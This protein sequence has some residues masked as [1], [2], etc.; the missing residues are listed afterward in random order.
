MPVSSS[1]R[2]LVLRE[3]RHTLGGVNAA[4][5]R[6]DLF[7]FRAR[8]IKLAAPD[9]VLGEG[10]IAGQLHDGERGPLVRPHLEVLHESGL[11]HL[12]EPT[13]HLADFIIDGWL[14]RFHHRAVPQT[15]Y[16]L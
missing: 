3:R 8:L 10:T 14:R 12:I 11:H 1:S 5:T 4:G 6:G 16:T 7:G 2:G 9:A 15:R 13:R